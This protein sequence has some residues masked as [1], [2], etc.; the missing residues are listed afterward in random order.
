MSS[1]THYLFNSDWQ[2]THCNVNFQGID[3]VLVSLGNSGALT[4][5]SM[6]EKSYRALTKNSMKEKSYRALTQNSMKEKS[7]RALTQNSMKEKSY[8]VWHKYI[9]SIHK[10]SSKDE[11]NSYRDKGPLTLSSIVPRF[12]SQL[13]CRGQQ[14]PIGCC[15]HHLN[16]HG[17]R[18]IVKGNA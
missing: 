3:N 6:K 14:G 13:Y 2:L 7:Y 9:G 1:S 16:M 11:S 12:L 15:C 18:T 8:Q 5:N 10:S 4:Q 17:V